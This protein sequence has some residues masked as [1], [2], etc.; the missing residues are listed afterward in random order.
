VEPY[1][2]AERFRRSHGNRFPHRHHD[3]YRHGSRI[4]RMR[5]S[6]NRGS[7][8]VHLAEHRLYNDHAVVRGIE[9]RWRGESHGVRRD[10]ALY[11]YMEHGC[12]NVVYY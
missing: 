2:Y 1:G 4:G 7:Y 12:N 3:V 6:E 8:R 10:G 9:P 5:F 11:L